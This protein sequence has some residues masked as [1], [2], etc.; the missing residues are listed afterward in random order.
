[1]PQG[2][3]QV[4]REWWKDALDPLSLSWHLSISSISNSFPYSVTFKQCWMWPRKPCQ[5]ALYFDCQTPWMRNVCPSCPLFT[6][7]IHPLWTLLNS[8]L[9]QMQNWHCFFWGHQ[10]TSF[11]LGR[12]VPSLH[13][14]RYFPNMHHYRLSAALKPPPTP[15]NKPKSILVPAFSWVSMCTASQF[16]YS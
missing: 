3:P 13:C 11:M 4:Q 7:H 10:Q 6:H 12:R 15:T 8:F 5:T 16:C 2:I 9:S 14:H 1:M